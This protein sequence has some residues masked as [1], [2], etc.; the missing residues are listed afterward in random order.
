MLTSN[1]FPL[2]VLEN[3]KK[4]CLSSLL[5][6]SIETITSMAFIKYLTPYSGKEDPEDW[7]ESYESNSMFQFIFQ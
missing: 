7:L 3:P 2:V 1:S 4:T 5:K 6:I